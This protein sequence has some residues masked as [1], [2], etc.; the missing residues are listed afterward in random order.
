M[1]GLCTCCS[2]D[3]AEPVPN[4]PP[5]GWCG[6]PATHIYV[7]DVLGT[8]CAHFACPAHNHEAD[9]SHTVHSIRSIEERVQ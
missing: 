8:E 7:H 2:H 4:A 3:D 9:S 5:C 1:S 6:Q